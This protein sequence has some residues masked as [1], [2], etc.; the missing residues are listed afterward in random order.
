MFQLQG[1]SI[2]IAGDRGMRKR[3]FMKAQIIDILKEHQAGLSAA[4]TP[5]EIITL[6]DHND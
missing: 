3:W 5:Q 4:E 2:A 6:I 1:Y